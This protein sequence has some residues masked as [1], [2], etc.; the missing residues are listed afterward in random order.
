[1]VAGKNRGENPH[2]K[3]LQGRAQRPR[4]PGN[5]SQGLPLS[6]TPCCCCGALTWIPPL[7]FP[8]VCECFFVG[9]GEPFLSLVAVGRNL[10]RRGWVLDSC[11]ISHSSVYPALFCRPC[12]PLQYAH[13]LCGWV[14]REREQPDHPNHAIAGFI[15]VATDVCIWGSA[16]CGPCSSV[17]LPSSASN[18]LTLVMPPTAPT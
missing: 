18:Q 17:S 9:G 7:Q 3:H 2:K 14:F 1:M 13:C 16:S 8:V 11:L 12:L 4:T 15:A 5:P 6:W 10:F